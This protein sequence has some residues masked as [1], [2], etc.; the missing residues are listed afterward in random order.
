MLFDTESD[1]NLLP[2]AD[3]VVSLFW[4]TLGC[5]SF[6]T[7]KFECSSLSPKSP[8]LIEERCMTVGGKVSSMAVVRMGMMSLVIINGQGHGHGWL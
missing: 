5:T 3:M 2:N 4:C 7:S 1:D 6:S 8:P